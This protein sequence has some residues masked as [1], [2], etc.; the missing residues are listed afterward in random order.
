MQKKKKV[1][2]LGKAKK[3]NNSKRKMNILKNRTLKMMFLLLMVAIVIYIIYKLIN[4]IITPTDTFMVENG[5]VSVE[6][7][8]TGYILR[9]ETVVKG[10][11]TQNGILQIKTEGEK[12]AKGEYVFRYY[13]NNE[14]GINERINEL[15]KQ[16]QEAMQ[17]QTD[18]FSGDIKSLDKQ[19]DTK[20]EGIKH[21]NSIQEISEYKNDISTYLTKKS[22]IAGDLSVAG[23]YINDLL[24]QKKQLENELASNSEYI[25]APVSG[26]ISYRIDDL[27]DALSPNNIDNLSKEYLNKLD[28]KTGQI[29]TTSNSMGKIVNNYEAYIA[30]LSK[31]EE[32]KN[33]EINDRVKLKLSSDD[34]ITAKIVDKKEQED[35]SILLVFK[36]T[37]NVEKLI[38]YRKI[39]FDIIWWSVDGLKIPN[40][41]ILY[42]NGKSYVVRNRA[43]YLD[44][45]LIKILDQNDKYCTITS[46][47]TQEL[48]DMGYSNKD[49]NNM[50][51]ITIYDEI[52]A[53]PNTENLE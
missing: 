1:G 4:L 36:I 8:T 9:E 34:E 7:T 53:D 11:N 47:S 21:K 22:K 49:I 38:G 24:E 2:K 16:I 39:S 5:T 10:E 6:E 23:S 52:L 15:D 46:Y 14:D 50:K 35:K 32:A 27:E 20:V 41:A 13:S 42:D 43:G 26:V 3:V 29:I 45:I 31:S 17:G 28:I 48:L 51:K 25:T 44:K 37:D 19:I 40:S 12:V 33:S 30:V 18:I